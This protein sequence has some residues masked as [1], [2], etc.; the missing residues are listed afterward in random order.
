ME[1]NGEEQ[2]LWVLRS[3][4]VIDQGRLY[5]NLNS[6]AVLD[7]WATHTHRSFV[8]PDRKCAN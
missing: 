7:F 3:L 4:S 2:Q 6:S 8:G 1:A 5:N